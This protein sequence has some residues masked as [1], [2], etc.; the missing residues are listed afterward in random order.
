MVGK[1]ISHYKI[2]EK[3][4]EGGMGAVYKAE[5]TKLKRTVALKFLPSEYTKDSE[6][7][8]RFI[9]EAQSAS[10]LDHPNICNIHEIDET[11]DGQIFLSMACYEGETLKEKIKRGPLKLGEAVDIAIQVARGLKEAHRKEIVH[12]DVKSGNIIVTNE[13]T[14]KIID[15]GLAKLLGYSDI[16]KAGTFM[17]T[18]AYMSPEQV[19]GTKSDHR[20]DI[21]SFGVVLYEMITGTLPFQGEYE[22]AVLYATLNKDPEPMADLMTGIP[23]ALDEIVN[24]ALAKEPE[25]R[26]QNVDEMLED[27][28]RVQA[29]YDSQDK[30]P[31]ARI[32]R[33]KRFLSRLLIPFIALV[34]CVFVVWI[35]KFSGFSLQSK[36]IPFD[37]NSLA[38]MPFKIQDDP[39]DTKGLGEV[40]ASLI[41]T[42]LNQS[43]FVQLVSLPHLLDIRDQMGLAPQRM[44]KQSEQIR[45][46][47]RA[48]V[49][50]LLSG[51]Y[52]RLGSR[53]ILKSDLIDVSGG[54]VINSQEV[55]SEDEDVMGMIDSLTSLI[56]IAL[57]L[58][59]EAYFEQDRSIADVT[60]RSREAY[61]NFLQGEKMAAKYHLQRAVEAYEKAVSLDPTFAT[62]YV[63]LAWTYQILKDEDK[64]NEALENAYKNIEHTKDHERYYIRSERALALGIREK[65]SQILLTW[66]ER[67][68]RDKFARLRLGNLYAHEYSM[69]D[70][71]IFQYQRALDLDSKYREAYNRLGYAYA[72]KKMKKEAIAS[73]K[74]YV[75]LAPDDANSHDSLGEVYMN[76][77]GDYRKAEKALL[78]AYEIRSDFTPHKL[79]EVNQLQG[80]YREAEALMRQSLMMKGMVPEGYKYFLMARLHF[81]K[82]DY[83]KALNYIETAKKRLPSYGKSY[84][85]SGLTHLKLDRLPEATNDLNELAK[86]DS[87]T[88]AYFHLLGNVHLER[89]DEDL[90]VQTLKKSVQMIDG[91]G[92][93]YVDHWE[94][95]QQTLAEAYFEAGDMD[96]AITEC[97]SIVNDNPSWARAYYLMGRIHEQKGLNEEALGFYRQFLKIWDDADRDLPEIVDAL[98][99]IDRLKRGL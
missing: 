64:A 57:P 77:I 62:A 58:P 65:A 24:K 28:Q 66:V 11:G 50:K 69:F 43:Q 6:A 54:W 26:Y 29:E 80:K 35:V 99:R 60:T 72:H 7:K 45:I 37:L 87:N 9:Q 5:D 51:N 38:V 98:Q 94:Y 78:K 86:I 22:Q 31:V 88:I 34:L 15:F 93:S 41:T 40:I 3:L 90:A 25:Q 74:K 59:D 18:V 46:A 8:E 68:P 33:P 23:A 42:D 32:V 92:D 2:I 91:I 12:R 30:I 48:G 96:S 17:G 56:K 52:F 49:A 63:R 71:A 85:L 55:E 19:T 16:T 95:Y 47:K 4:G 27:L 82:M 89:G 61:F 44:I 67:Y 76:L 70:Q 1:T 53:Y 21:F 14:A 73:L 10:A 13:G 79:A 36:Y 83:Q 84:W 20:S 97:Q 75:K 39:D 81:Q